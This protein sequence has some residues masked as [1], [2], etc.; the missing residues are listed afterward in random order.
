MARLLM[1][2]RVIRRPAR[3]KRPICPASRKIL[4]DR[5]R[6]AWRPGNPQKRQ[7]ATAL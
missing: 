1:L 4:G 2:L 5:W 6:V 3:R 7:D